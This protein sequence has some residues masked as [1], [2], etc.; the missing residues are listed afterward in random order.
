VLVESTKHIALMDF[1]QL[2]FGHVTPTFEKIVERK[3]LALIG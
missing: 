3:N 1:I 2:K